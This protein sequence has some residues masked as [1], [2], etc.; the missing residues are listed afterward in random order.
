M[1]D[2]YLMTDS[3]QALWDILAILDL[4]VKTE[5]TGQ[6]HAKDI[7]LDIIGTIY[8][9]TG[10]MIAG[11]NGFEFPEQL[12]VPGFHANIRGVLTD[13]QQSALPLIPAPVAPIR[14]WA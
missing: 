2:F 13:E 7:N 12:P 10:K 8:K 4:A 6:Y 11:E 5:E 14:T 1:Q 3:E 9:P